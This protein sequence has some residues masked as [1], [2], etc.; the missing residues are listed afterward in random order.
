MSGSS[1]QLVG[2]AT[3]ASG[4][5]RKAEMSRRQGRG[6]GLE[7]LPDRGRGSSQ[8]LHDEVSGAGG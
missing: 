1:Q 6:L 3:A 7:G 4:R 2:G 8:E 5:L